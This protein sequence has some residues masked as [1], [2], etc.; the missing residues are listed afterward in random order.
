VSRV[1]GIETRSISKL[2]PDAHRPSHAGLLNV[3]EVAR[4][5]GCSVR[6]VHRLADSGRMPG[7]VRLGGLVRWSLKSLESWIQEGCPPS[8]SPGGS[9]RDRA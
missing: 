5:L 9:R 1:D 4:L 2:D 8:R 7:P 3:K 6:H